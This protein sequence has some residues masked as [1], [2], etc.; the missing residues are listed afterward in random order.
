[1]VQSWTLDYDILQ[2]SSIQ[3]KERRPPRQT[4]SGSSPVHPHQEVSYDIL[5][6]ASPYTN[7]QDYPFYEHLLRVFLLSSQQG[8]MACCWSDGKIWA[9]R[10]IAGPVSGKSFPDVSNS[11]QE[12]KSVVL[13]WTRLRNKRNNGCSFNHPSLRLHHP[14]LSSNLYTTTRG[15]CTMKRSGPTRRKGNL[16]G[17]ALKINGRAA[18]V[19][20][21][22]RNS[23]MTTVR[24]AATTAF[25]V[26][27]ITSKPARKRNNAP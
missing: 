15:D 17:Q 7:L 2:G 16:Y 4:A 23:P 5:A 6:P 26:H 19:M 24:S 20:N 1:M 9:A 22:P 25:I 21:T 13:K 27:S 12:L 8:R 14:R 11:A 18:A 10:L 3:G